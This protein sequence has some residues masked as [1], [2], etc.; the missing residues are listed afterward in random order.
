MADQVVLVV[1]PDLFSF[2]AARRAVEALDLHQGIDR[3]RVLLNPAVRNE[4]G[5]REV[6][7][8]LGMAPF[9]AV[10]FDSGVERAQTRGRLLP[11]RGRRAARDLRL[12]ADKLMVRPE[13]PA[14]PGPVEGEVS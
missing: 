11:P 5:R 8:V 7:R 14:Q 9:G 13:R 3:C 12:L 10:R 1:S 2:H 6:E 4:F